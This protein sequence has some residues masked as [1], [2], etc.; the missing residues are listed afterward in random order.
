MQLVILAGGRG[1]RL[2]E[3]T[4]IKPKPLVDVGNKPII[5]HIMKIYSHY[6]I[7]DFIICL[8]YKGYLIKEY[9]ANYSLHNT[10]LTID[11]K[12]NSRIIHQKKGEDWNY[13]FLDIDDQLKRNIPGYDAATKKAPNYAELE[14][15][16]DDVATV[17]VWSKL[18]KIDVSRAQTLINRSERL[19]GRIYR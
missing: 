13:V 9:F 1:S 17:I 6:G 15:I 14:N 4:L 7:K 19:L 2:T 18:D 11:L 8:G 5:W 16:G 12:K 10:D 3:E